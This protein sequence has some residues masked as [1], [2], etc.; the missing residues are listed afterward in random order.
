MIYLQT[1]LAESN[2]KSVFP[3]PGAGF[4]AISYN[5]D[6]I[7][8]SNGCYENVFYTGLKLP[9]GHHFR[10]VDLYTT[11]NIDINIRVL[12]NSAKGNTINFQN[13][14]TFNLDSGTNK[15]TILFDPYIIEKGDTF[16]LR[17]FEEDEKSFSV[18]GA[19]F[20]LIN[21]DEMIFFNGFN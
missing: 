15:T 19:Q 8:E 7:N 1:T 10:Q 2:F 6:S 12:L 13:S 14:D 3:I 9:T 5:V 16:L 11:S 18:C 21:K 20:K 4:K 17:L